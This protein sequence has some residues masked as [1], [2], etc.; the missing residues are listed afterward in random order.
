M[1][2]DFDAWNKKKKSLDCQDRKILF[3]E[4]EVWWCSIGL[5]LGEEVY[6]KGKEFRR[7]VVVLRKLTGTSG[8]VLPLTSQ[9]KSGTWYQRIQFDDKER[10]VMMHQIRMVSTKRFESRMAS[11]SKGEFLELKNAVGKFYDILAQSSPRA[12]PGISG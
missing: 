6:G 9:K 11:M 12:N 10:Y 3:K 2:K 7:P 4:G 5:N 8:V 1:E